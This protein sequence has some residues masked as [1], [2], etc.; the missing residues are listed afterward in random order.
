MTFNRIFAGPVAVAIL[1]AVAACD[2]ADAGQAAKA[3]PA[4]E[5]PQDPPLPLREINRWIEGVRQE[6][7]DMGGRFGGVQDHLLPGDFNGDGRMDYVLR[8]GGV[9][10]PHPEGWA[11]GALAPGNAGPS[12]DFLISQPG[13]GYQQVSGFSSFIEAS[14]IQ[15]Q[16]ARDRIVID[17]TWFEADGEVHKVIWGWTGEE[18]DV[19]ER[20]DAQGRPVDSNGRLIRAAAPAGSASTSP[21]RD[22]FWVTGEAYPVNR[23]NGWENLHEEAL[24]F[25]GSTFVRHNGGDADACRIVEQSTQGAETR[26]TFQCLISCGNGGEGPCPERYDPQRHVMTIRSLD[27]NRFRVSVSRAPYDYWNGEYTWYGT[28]W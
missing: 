3:T 11:G 9:S 8:W 13:G 23:G 10:C 1:G 24:E 27:R 25:A 28:E 4:A 18:M 21:F 16:G 26:V 14:N 17:G 12:N 20:Q 6:C 15:R 5:A 2:T 22:G 19:V 7:E